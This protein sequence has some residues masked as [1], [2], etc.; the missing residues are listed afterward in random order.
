M[1]P[2]SRPTAVTVSS[3]DEGSDQS[4]AWV[5]VN[6]FNKDNKREHYKTPKQQM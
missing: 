6:I 4:A 2:R 5:V 3:V 1:G